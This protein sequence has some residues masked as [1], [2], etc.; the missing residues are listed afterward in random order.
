MTEPESERKPLRR[1]RRPPGLRLAL[2][3]GI[4]L[5]LACPAISFWPVAWIA[6][7][8]LIL[9]V[10]RASR[11]R[12][13]FWRGYLFGWVYL[14]SVWYWTGLTIV[15]WTHSEIGWLAWF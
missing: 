9:S 2:L 8:P 13:A 1:S 3:A 11:F 7:V 5:W 14:G 15:A 4:L 12:R 10:T 6:V